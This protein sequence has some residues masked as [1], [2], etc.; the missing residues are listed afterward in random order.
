MVGG[1][2]IANVV[3]YLYHLVMGRILG[4]VEYGVLASLYSILYLTGIIPTSASV[5]IVKFISS[6]KDKDVASVYSTINKLIFK[7]SVIVSIL[8]ILVSPFIKNF[9]RIE[10]VLPVI[11]LSPI[12]FLTLLTLV[13]QSASQGLLKFAG[14]AVPSIIVSLLKLALGIAF[15]FLGW[16]VFGAVFGIVIGYL[17]AYFYSASFINK[18]LKPGKLLRYDL[19]PFYKYS[20]PVLLQAL[21]FTSLFTTDLLLVK[22]FFNPFQAGIYAALST[23]GKIIFFC[24]LS[25]YCHHVPDS[26]QKARRGSRT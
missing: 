14:S 7:L 12:V 13:N 9:L 18:I 22:H 21:A 26:F 11:L 16:S 1:N 17:V 3:N 24:H 2:M 5:S 20:L 10:N 23:L 19:K 25:G 15:V 4:P 8:L 6:A